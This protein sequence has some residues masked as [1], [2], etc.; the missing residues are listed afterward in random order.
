MRQ[1]TITILTI[2]ATSFVFIFSLISSKFSLN[3]IAAGQTLTTYTVDNTNTANPER[4]FYRN[5]YGVPALAELQTYKSNKTT[6]YRQIYDISSFIQQP[7]STSFLAQINSDAAIFRQ[8]GAKI[9][10]NFQYSNGGVIPNDAAKTIIVGHLEQLRPYLTSNSDVIAIFASSFIGDYGE[11]T[12]SSNENISFVENK[13]YISSGFPTLQDLSNGAGRFVVNQNTREIVSKI[14]DVLPKERSFAI[15]QPAT[16]KQLVNSLEPLT[17]AEAFSK[18]DK[19]RLGHQNDSLLGNEYE[20]ATFI[21][22]NTENLVGRNNEEDYY[23]KDAKYTPFIAEAEFFDNG[24][25]GQCVDAL[26]LIKSR[27]ISAINELFN[28]Q[29]LNIWKTQGCYEEIAKKLGY[30][31]ILNSSDIPAQTNQNQAFNLKLKL[32][33]DGYATPFNERK[34]EVILR[35]KVTGQIYPVDVTNQSDPRKWFP[36]N[37][38]FELNLNVT[39]NV[40][41]GSYDTLLN[42]PDPLP[43]IKNNPDYSIRLS[44]QNVWESTTGYNNLS[45]TIDITPPT[46]TLGTKLSIKANLGGAFDNQIAAMRTS[47]KE[48]NMIPVAQPYAAAPFRY[49]GSESFALLG[50]IPPDTVD[51][52]LVE[53]KSGSTTILKKA[54]IIKSNGQVVDAI[55]GSSSIDLASLATGNYKL[56]IRH[57]NHV[58]I[59]TDNDVTI[60]ANTN[61]IV[62]FTTNAN[63]KSL[64]QEVVLTDSSNKK[65]YGMKKGNINGELGISTED[66][67]IAKTLQGSILYSSAD[68]NLDGVVNAID[69]ATV[70]LA[71]DSIEVL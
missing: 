67:T 42:F 59:A 15:R 22:S 6:L 32:Q 64:N 16:K 23:N 52:V 10:L 56:I 11:F 35:N 68:A 12:I 14:L 53:L 26:K 25:S 69:K 39:A 62:D 24:A 18:S 55:S 47:L 66:K 61:T 20:G 50:D 48:N 60:T 36:E 3:S 19:A 4:G 43:S 58:A 54:A 2:T 33:N 34:F 71:P 44:N 41:V 9:L 37:G 29:T 31:F 27:R 40:P 70:R 30:R 45:H 65:I 13:P 1:K 63:V 57:R 8:A 46:N 17:D 51:W 7:L 38:A 5:Y 28:I 21:Y 49:I